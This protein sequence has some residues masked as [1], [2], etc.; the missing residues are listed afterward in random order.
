MSWRAS[1][2][3]PT[4]HR[5]VATTRCAQGSELDQG[6]RDKA[7]SESKWPV[8][9]AAK[10]L[11]HPERL[12]RIVSAR[13]RGLFFRLNGSSSRLQ[14]EAVALLGRTSP[15]SPEALLWR[16][17]RSHHHEFSRRAGSVVERSQEE[18]RLW[19][20]RST[21]CLPGSWIGPHGGQ[22]EHFARESIDQLDAYR[23]RGK[24]APAGCFA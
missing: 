1:T 15:R 6:L 14:R 4:F 12:C 7:E 5:T 11:A 19:W 13:S 20:R 2:R 16:R 3:S 22:F 10:Q 24:A 23:N 17:G 8:I 18:F 21:R 9:R